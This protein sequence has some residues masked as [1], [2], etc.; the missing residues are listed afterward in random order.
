MTIKTVELKAPHRHAGRD[1][2]VG[3][4]LTLPADKADWLIGLGRADDASAAK[5]ADKPKA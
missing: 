4:K 3:A 5:P 1:Y 2:P